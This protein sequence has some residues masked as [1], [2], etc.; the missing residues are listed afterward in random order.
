MDIHIMKLAA[1]RENRSGNRQKLFHIGVF[2]EWNGT[3]LAWLIGAM[4]NHS[5]IVGSGRCWFADGVLLD[6]RVQ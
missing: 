5:Q 4:Q 6:Q 2:A 1:L 3:M